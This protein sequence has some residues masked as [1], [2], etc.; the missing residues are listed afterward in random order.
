MTRLND[1]IDDI[2]RQCARDLFSSFGLEITPEPPDD[3]P[4]ELI[5]IIGFAGDGVRGTVSIA[6]SPGVPALALRSIPG[7]ADSGIHDW[8]AESTNQL[9]GRIKNKILAWGVSVS[10]ALPIVLRGL[11]V[12]LYTPSKAP[13]RS[14]GFR[15]NSERILVLVDIQAAEE[16]ILTKEE[17]PE[18]EVLDEGGML[19][20]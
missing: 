15:M 11:Q 12:R 10:I 8:L 4:V 1:V 18:A 20:F 16:L 13:I 9:M 7:S 5:G 17:S 2:V 6:V 3:N 19:L 14:Y